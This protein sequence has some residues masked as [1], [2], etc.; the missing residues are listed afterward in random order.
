LHYPIRSKI[1]VTHENTLAYGNKKIALDNSQNPHD[2]FKTHWMSIE[3][4]IS[5][6]SMPRPMF[7]E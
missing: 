7:K 2:W 1:G 5:N 4:I 3:I 6:I